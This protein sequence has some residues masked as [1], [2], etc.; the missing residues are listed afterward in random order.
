MLRRQSAGFHFPSTGSPESR[1]S[2]RTVHTGRACG[3]CEGF[4][5]AGKELGWLMK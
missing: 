5:T 1:L 3:F 4:G 2:E